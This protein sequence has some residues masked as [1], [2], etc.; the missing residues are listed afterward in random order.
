MDG[1]VGT[2]NR[3]GRSHAGLALPELLEPSSVGREDGH[4]Q[5]VKEM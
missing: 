1:R 4:L 3:T 2:E 5:E